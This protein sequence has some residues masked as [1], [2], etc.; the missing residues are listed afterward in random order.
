[1][2]SVEVAVVG[3]GPA[4]A[5]AAALLARAGREVLLFEAAARPCD[6]VCGEF[7]G[8]EALRGLGGLG[9]DAAALGAERLTRLA[10]RPARG[11]GAAKQTP[12][13]FPA[14]ALSRP[15][16]DAAIMQAAVRA[17]AELRR[18]VAVRAARPLGGGW[19][20][21]C[22]DGETLRA[23]IL[24]PATGKRGLRG[25]ADRRPLAAV[26]L[27]ARLRL[28][29][30]ARRGWRGAV[31]LT[32]FRGGY[33]GLLPVEGERANLALLCRREA[34]AGIGPGWP[35][36]RGFL[37][38]QAPS[39]A[40]VLADA[41]PCG[42]GRLAAACP[43]RGYLL[44]AAAGE[45]SFP[46]GDRLAHTPPFTGDGIGLALASA[47]LAAGHIA[48]GLPAP[49]YLRAAAARFRPAIRRAGLLSAL[50]ESPFGRSA[51]IGMGRAPALLRLL[52]RHTRLPSA[53]EDFALML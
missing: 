11:D 46:V 32:L 33:A 16:L 48:R 20:L 39:L 21:H 53:A 47:A 36:L 38:G 14:R 28:A 23:R 15:L 13:P 17:G 2:R 50:A 26:G 51:L 30:A 1:M 9:I 7:L 37:L 40:P 18:G 45:N 34:V 44:A 24:V 19:E 12:L 27:K 10:L 4:G 6:K 8:P 22:G 3:A 31:E 52:A 35:D 43:G 49:D 42:E 29:P 5:S 41:E 25:L